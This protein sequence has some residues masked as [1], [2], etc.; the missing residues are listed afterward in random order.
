MA[1]TVLGNETLDDLNYHY[2]NFKFILILRTPI[3]KR[4]IKP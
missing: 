3:Q 2:E 4:S 1:A